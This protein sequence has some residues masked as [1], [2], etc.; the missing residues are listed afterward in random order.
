MFFDSGEQLLIYTRG[1]GEVGKSRVI[2]AIEMGFI[3]LSRKKELV[4]F[5]ST[6][7]VANGIGESIV[8]IVL[9]VNN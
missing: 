1:K 6:S 3:L 4:I 5:V 2:K 9:D 8:H 7:S